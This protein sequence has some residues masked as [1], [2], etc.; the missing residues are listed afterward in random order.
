MYFLKFEKAAV[1]EKFRAVSITS[2][3][4]H[5]GCGST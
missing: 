4:L 5:F 2:N 1:I 3:I